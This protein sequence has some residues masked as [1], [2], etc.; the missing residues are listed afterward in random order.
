MVPVEIGR[1]GACLSIEDAEF[2]LARRECD[3]ILLP[4]LIHITQGNCFCEPSGESDVF[5]K[6]SWC[7]LVQHT[8]AV[9]TDR[10][11]VCSPG[12]RDIWESI[13]VEVLDYNFYLQSREE[14]LALLECPI[15]IE[16]HNHDVLLI[17]C[18]DQIGD[19]VEINI[20]CNDPV[21]ITLFTN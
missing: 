4:V 20:C 16:E 18:I 14:S 8:R 6:R 10:G 17:I 5:T 19:A 11:E 7:V 15:R 3:H 9:I 2:P 21:W 12:K 13:P 1:A